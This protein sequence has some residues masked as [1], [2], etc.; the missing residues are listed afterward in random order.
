MFIYIC[1]YLARSYWSYTYWQYW[2]YCFRQE[3]LEIDLE[4]DLEFDFEIDFEI[5]LEIDR[6]PLIFFSQFGANSLIIFALI[7]NE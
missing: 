1:V 6:F 4:F 5:D 3:H 2:Q 7:E